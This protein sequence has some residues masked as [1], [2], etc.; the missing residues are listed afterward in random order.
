MV[1]SIF[2]A[3]EPVAK[4]RPRMGKGGHVYTPSR[5]EKAEFLIRETWKQCFGDLLIA[6]R[7]EPVTLCVTVKLRRPKSHYGTGRNAGQV[8]LGAPRFPTGKPDFDNL[9][10][11]VSDALTGLAYVDDAQIFHGSLVKEYAA[12]QGGIGWSILV[13]RTGREV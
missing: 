9:L 12:D 2:V 3:A 10:K 1:K 13:G 6:E 7:G 11:T 5:T 8:K 4:A